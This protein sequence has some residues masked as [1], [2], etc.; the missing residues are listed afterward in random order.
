MVGC[1]R[2]F[3]SGA[4][5]GLAYG[6]ADATAKTF[7]PSLP[8]PPV[9]CPSLPS[10]CLPHPFSE[11]TYIVSSGALNCTPTNPE[12]GCV[13]YVAILQQLGDAEIVLV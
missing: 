10:V 2:G 5:C 4:R 7:D 6:P 3:L 12:V 9:Y 11:M 13:W 8:L 1:W